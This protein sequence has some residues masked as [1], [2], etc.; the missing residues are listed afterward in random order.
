LS[1]FSHQ[2]SFTKE[3]DEFCFSDAGPFPA[4]GLWE[5]VAT[6]ALASPAFVS[7]KR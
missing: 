6:I 3:R 4:L 1:L 5:A 7:G 2:T